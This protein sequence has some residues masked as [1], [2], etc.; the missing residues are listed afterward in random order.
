MADFATI[1][2]HVWLLEKTGAP[3]TFLVFGNDREVPALWLERYGSLATG[4]A[5]Y[6]LADGGRLELLAPPSAPT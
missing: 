6:F 3:T 5:F 4:V 2:E 1:A